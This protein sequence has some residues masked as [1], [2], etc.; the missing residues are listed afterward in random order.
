MRARPD[1]S[2][3]LT[4]GMSGL[5]LVSGL[6]GCDVFRSDTPPPTD[7]QR[8]A[9]HQAR[10]EERAKA[11]STAPTLRQEASEPDVAPV[12]LRPYTDWSLPETAADALGRIG[13]A[14][15]PQLAEALHHPDPE[16]RRNATRVLA[17]I[18]PEAILAVPELRRLLG[19]SNEAVRQAAA[20]AL[21]QIG[22]GAASA[23]PELIELLQQ[24]PAVDSVDEPADEPAD[25]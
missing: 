12:M 13:V 17:R 14:A 2:R 9:I 22:P 8:A 5:L 11:V 7:Q 21:G 25:P 1:H 6:A 16:I 19:D 18:G 3:T 15:V 20:R 24:A 4:W 23:V 10:L